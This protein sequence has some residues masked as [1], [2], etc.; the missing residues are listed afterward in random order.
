MMKDGNK[1]IIVGWHVAHMR[2][3]RFSSTNDIRDIRDIADRS[4][5]RRMEKEVDE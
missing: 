5:E 4:R 2:R 3:V 1:I